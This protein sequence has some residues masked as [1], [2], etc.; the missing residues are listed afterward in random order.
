MS[1]IQVSQKIF[2]IWDELWSQEITSKSDF[3]K[4]VV[5]LGCSPKKSKN[6]SGYKLHFGNAVISAHLKHGRNKGEKGELFAPE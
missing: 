1:T 2:N 5:A 3:L 6:G 4:L